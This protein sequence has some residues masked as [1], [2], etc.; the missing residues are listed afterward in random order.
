MKIAL[1]TDSFLPI[2]D[3]VGRVVVEYAQYLSHAGHECY[4]ITPMQ[5]TGYRGNFPFEIL[6]FLSVNQPISP[7]YKAGFAVLDSHYC[8]RV[9]QIDFDIIHAHDPGPAGMEAVRLAEKRKIPLIGTFH[10]KYYSD[11]RRLVHSET[12]ATLGVKVI[13]NFYEKCDEVW[14]VSENAA[15]ELISYGFNKEIRIMPNS[16][17][18]RPYDFAAP[19]EACEKFSLDPRRPILLY[20]GQIDIKKNLLLVLEAASILQQKGCRFQ[21]VLAGQ[22]K[23][24]EMLEQ[25]AYEL[26]IKN[27]KFVGHVKEESLLYGLYRAASLFLFPSQYDTAGLVVSEAAMMGTP[28]VVVSGSAP[29]EIIIHNKNGLVCEESA[30]DLAEMVYHYLQEMTESERESLSARAKESI[31]VSCE[32]IMEL[33]SDR[34]KAIIQQFST[35]G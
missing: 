4:V 2:V 23:D 11:I 34:Y 19:R 1:C 35:G 18:I 10:S 9:A 27:I 8:E 28:S 6:D 20:V 30:Q 12:L 3:G 13:A 7:Q 29:S 21:L 31:P 22:G 17:R 32:Q 24:R 15:R 14:T 25:K 5:N 16:V 33:V 26:G